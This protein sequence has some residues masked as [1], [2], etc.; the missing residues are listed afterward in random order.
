LSAA[1]RG[2]EF[3]A[4]LEYISVLRSSI[5]PLLLLTTRV[6]C[7][8]FAIEASAGLSD[9]TESF[10]LPCCSLAQYGQWRQLESILF[11]Q[12]GHCVLIRSLLR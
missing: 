12:L 10:F 11:P 2:T 1:L 5:E 8:S 9:W 6:C 7:L 4:G 3:G